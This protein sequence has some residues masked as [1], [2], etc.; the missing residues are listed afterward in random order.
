MDAP[1][2]VLLVDD[3]ADFAAVAADLLEREDDR[4]DVTTE[5][6]A[7]ASL[8]R[9]AETEFDCLVSDY[10]MPG[11]DGLELLGAVRERWPELPFVLFTGKGS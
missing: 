8:D 3:V 2:R 11:L 4:L 10:Q 7:S 5:T 1:I 6:D 9:L